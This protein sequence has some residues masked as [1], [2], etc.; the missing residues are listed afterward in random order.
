MQLPGSSTL[1]DLARNRAEPLRGASGSVGELRNRTCISYRDSSPRGEPSRSLQPRPAEAGASHAL[2]H[3]RRE[4]SQQ[5]THYSP[6]TNYRPKLLSRQH[7]R[8]LPSTQHR[9]G[10]LLRRRTSGITIK[11]ASTT[12]SLFLSPVRC[13]LTWMPPA[14]RL[15]PSVTRPAASV[16]SPATDLPEP[17]SISYL[18]LCVHAYNIYMSSGSY[19]T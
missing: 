8:P 10:G 6:A 14:P 19:R 18:H 1:Q 17:G 9:R 16:E 5:L 3:V 15:S 11:T 2:A 4:K 12:G 7:V 13:S